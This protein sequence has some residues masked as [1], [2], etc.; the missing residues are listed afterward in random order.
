MGQEFLDG[1]TVLAFD[2][3]TTGV[4]TAN[5]RIVQI[6]LI[7]SNKDGQTISYESLVN[8]R[9]PIPL[10]ASEVHGIYDD[11]VKHLG[12]FSTIAQQVYGLIELSLIHI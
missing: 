5:D 9:R 6:A 2:L 10:G 7:G 4:S 12:D 8:P 11:K 1:E 3:E